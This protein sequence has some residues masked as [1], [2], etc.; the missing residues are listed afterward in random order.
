MAIVLAVVL[1][2]F[3]RTCHVRSPTLLAMPSSSTFV[4]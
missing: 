3:D 4:C 2:P 1:P